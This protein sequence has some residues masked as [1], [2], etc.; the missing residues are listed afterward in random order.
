MI[1]KVKRVLPVLNTYKIDNQKDIKQMGGITMQSRLK[2]M[3]KGAL[4]IRRHDALAAQYCGYLHHT[5]RMKRTTQE[6]SASELDSSI[7]SFPQV[8]KISRPMSITSRS[9]TTSNFLM[10]CTMRVNLLGFVLPPS[11]PSS[12]RFCN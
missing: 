9:C 12:S 2:K 4:R 11:L 8:A 10:M 7:E 6:A 3:I 5:A 1:S